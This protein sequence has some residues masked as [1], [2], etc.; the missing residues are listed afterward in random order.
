MLMRLLSHD[1]DAYLDA[2]HR[3][4]FLKYGRVV[5]HPKYKVY[6]K[7][8]I[9]N[10]ETNVQEIEAIDLQGDLLDILNAAWYSRILLA[11]PNKLEAMTKFYQTLFSRRANIRWDS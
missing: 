4:M 5:D 7:K 1:D 10:Y 6:A 8:M 11:Q 2:L 3:T 9:E